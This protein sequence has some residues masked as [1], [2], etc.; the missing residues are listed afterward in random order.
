MPDSELSPFSFASKEGRGLDRWETWTPVFTSLTVVGATAYSGRYRFVGHKLEFQVQFSAA[1]SVASVAG[2]TYLALPT[3]AK[4]LA[5][6]AV[7][8]DAT[9]KQAVGSCHIDVTNSRVY[10][11]TQLASGDVFNLAGWCET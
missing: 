3:A 9:S 8:T 10:L 4:G 1:T 6:H 11:P 2:T 5:G 7:M